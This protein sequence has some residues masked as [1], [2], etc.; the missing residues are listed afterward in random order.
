[1]KRFIKDFKEYVNLGDHLEVGQTGELMEAGIGIAS[2]PGAIKMRHSP[3]RKNAIGISSGLI[4][5]YNEDEES[6]AGWQKPQCD[7]RPNTNCKIWTPRRTIA[8]LAAM[9]R[10]EDDSLPTVENH[11]KGG[12]VG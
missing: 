12:V 6:F 2:N 3:I 8:T 5:Y 4:E 11:K 9:W 1:M 10:E 7:L